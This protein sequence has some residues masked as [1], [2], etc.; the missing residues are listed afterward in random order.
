M[1]NRTLQFIGYAYGSEPVEITACINDEVVFSGAVDTIDGPVEYNPQMD[2]NP[3]LFSVENNPL[4]PVD[5]AGSYTMTVTVNSAGHVQLGPILSNFMIPSTLQYTDKSYLANSSINGTTLTVGSVESGA[6]K[7]G[8]FLIAVDPITGASLTDVIS[9]GT[10]ILSGSGSTWTINKEQTVEQTDILAGIPNMDLETIFTNC[11]YAV[12][13]NSEGT[14]DPRS[15]V[16][17]DGEL[18]VPPLPKSTG[19]WT[20]NILG[21]STLECQLTVSHPLRT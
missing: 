11:Y 1:F 2:S 9:I 17:I 13:A 18:Q 6:V 7:A 20:W 19:I 3:V 14:P 10:Q 5:F 12:P 4:F 15:S 16:K 8:Q 21:G